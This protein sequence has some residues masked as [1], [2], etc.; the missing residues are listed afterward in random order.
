MRIAI[1]SDTH[2]G[3]RAGLTP[4]KWQWPECDPGED[5]LRSKFA[6]IQRIL[7]GWFAATVK[8]LQPID[9]LIHM[10]D[11]IDGTAEKSAG[12]ELITTDLKEQ[13]DIA[14][15]CIETVE[16]ARTHL[17]YGTP[18]HTASDGQD[19][20]AVLAEMVCADIGGHEWYDAEG[21]VFDC[22]HKVSSSII[23]H[24]RHTGPS[25]D[26]L[27]NVLWA[28]RGLQPQ[29]RVYIRGHVHYHT[30]CGDPTRLVITA[31]CLQAWSKYGSRQCAGTID[32]GLL[33]FDCEGGE[34]SWKPYLL[35][36]APMAAQAQPA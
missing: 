20:E 5:P 21:V 15:E 12:T 6:T 25:R 13:C 18:Y 11:A 29:A 23:P 26:W 2:C 36:M 9:V 8:K 17:L 31:P 4:P 34:Y 3:H 28:E 14:R 33:V 1:I 24:G 32:L 7:W 30:Y 19:W 16:A 10:G 35:D 22:K 27:W